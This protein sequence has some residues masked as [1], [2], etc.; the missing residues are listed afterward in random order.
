MM[1]DSE[2]ASILGR[3]HT[4]QSGQNSG[5]QEHDVGTSGLLVLVF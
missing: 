1:E 4:S 5:G 2:G 3:S